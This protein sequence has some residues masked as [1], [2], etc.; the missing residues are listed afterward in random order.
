MRARQR[1]Q[2][3]I[4]TMN[5]DGSDKE[6]ITFGPLTGTAATFSPD[7][8]SILFSIRVGIVTSPPHP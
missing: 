8:K 2:P 4:W 5:A 3:H 1:E 6:Q 7:G